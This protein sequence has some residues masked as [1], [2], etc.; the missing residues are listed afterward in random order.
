MET[1]NITNNQNMWKIMCTNWSMVTL[2]IWK[3]KRTTD[4]YVATT[5]ITI[6]KFRA[7]NSRVYVTAT[8]PDFFRPRTVNS[9]KFCR[10]NA[11]RGSMV[12]AYG[13][14]PN[15]IMHENKWFWTK[16][17]YKLY[18]ISFFRFCLQFVQILQ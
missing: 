17:N 11:S 16:M 7:H 9:T 5:G 13:R 4:F 8:V 18:S 2:L 1:K 3:Q 15:F 10:Y 12:T 14:T 6:D